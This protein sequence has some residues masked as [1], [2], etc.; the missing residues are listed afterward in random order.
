MRSISLERRS[1]VLIRSLVSLVLSIMWLIEFYV[2]V[3]DLRES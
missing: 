3:V 2:V 1:C